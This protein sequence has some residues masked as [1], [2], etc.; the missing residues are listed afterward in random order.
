MSVNNKI[1]QFQKLDPADIYRKEN[2]NIKSNLQKIT[3]KLTE[4]TIKS[5]AADFN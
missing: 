3:T 5:L 4:I 2:N 1:K